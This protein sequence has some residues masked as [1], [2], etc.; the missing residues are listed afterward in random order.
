MQDVPS[1]NYRWVIV[2][3]LWLAHVIS[4]LNFSSLGILA[5]FFMEDLSLSSAQVGLFVSAV[6]IGS[7][8]SQV[9][10]GLVTDLV[11]VRLILPLAIGAMAVFLSLFSLSSSYISA[12][13]VLMVYGLA[14]GTI[15]PPASVVRHKSLVI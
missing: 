2:G 11:S 9:P 8:L 1:N 10:A 14:S 6:S 15:S 12:L 13:I 7:C 4:F 3:I 5:P